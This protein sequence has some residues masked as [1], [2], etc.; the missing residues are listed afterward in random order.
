MPQHIRHVIGIDPG[1][2]TGAIVL[3]ERNTREDYLN[4]LHQQDVTPKEGQ[5]SVGAFMEAY[6]KTVGVI[7]NRTQEGWGLSR[8]YVEFPS[9]AYH[10]KGNSATIIKVCRVAAEVGMGII[11]R[12]GHPCVL[13]GADDVMRRN[14]TIIANDE[15]PQ[16]YDRIFEVEP[17]SEHVI[18]AALILAQIEKVL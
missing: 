15:R 18:D 7:P 11:R 17:K 16:L 9:G 13:V 4:I 8:T 3:A 6:K 2:T 10:G 1:L 5:S 12:M 14:G